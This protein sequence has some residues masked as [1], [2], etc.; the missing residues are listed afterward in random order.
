MLRFTEYTDIEN[1]I[2]SLLEYRISNHPIGS[3]VTWG[4]K[5]FDKL[6]S[7]LKQDL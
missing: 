7:G 3:Y 2:E 1:Y 5:K 6:P 4:S